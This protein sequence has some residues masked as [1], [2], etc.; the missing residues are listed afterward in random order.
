MFFGFLWHV[1][2]YGVLV[3]RCSGIFWCG[4]VE[5][6]DRV[7]PKPKAPLSM[8]QLCV[9]VSQYLSV[10]SIFLNSHT[11]HTLASCHFWSKEL[12]FFGAAVGHALGFV[13]FGG[14]VST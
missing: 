1:L 11:L 8:A 7:P 12:L 3:R 5:R 6:Q 2:W 4:F 9:S 14:A 13:C 10:I